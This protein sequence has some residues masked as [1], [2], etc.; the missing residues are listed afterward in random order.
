MT[1]R[2]TVQEQYE[3]VIVG[4]RQA[5]QVETF[6]R[7]QRIEAQELDGYARQ[8]VVL[9]RDAAHVVIAALH[10]DAFEMEH[11]GGDANRAAARK[12]WQLA[13]AIGQ[14]MR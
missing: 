3:D 11:R 12:Q 1:A 2:Q 6:A 9:S 14:A 5:G 10:R 8:G 7:P 4:G 13:Q